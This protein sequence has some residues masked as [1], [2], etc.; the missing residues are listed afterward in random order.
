[1][2]GKSTFDTDL[3][4]NERILFV[5]DEESLVFTAKQTLGRLGYHVVAERNPNKALEIFMEQ[6]D[7]FDIVITDMTMPEMTGEKFVNEIMKIRPDIPVVLCTGHSEHILGKKMEGMG[8][9]A[10][11]MKPALVREI[12][13]AIRQVLATTRSPSDHLRG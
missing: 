8:I 4:G 10:L 9:R 7:G 6:P 1:M 12:A 11:V 2:D 3:K 5:D 13:K